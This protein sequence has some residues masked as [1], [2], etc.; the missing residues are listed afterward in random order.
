MS[1]T[2]DELKQ[3]AQASIEQRGHQLG[4]WRD[5][6][7]HSSAD[8]KACSMGVTVTPRTAPNEIDIGGPACGMHC[9]GVTACPGCGGELYLLTALLKPTTSATSTPWQSRD[10]SFYI[11]GTCKHCRETI[12]VGVNVAD[13]PIV[14]PF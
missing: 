4:E 10:A 3:E 1:K 6:P 14:V 12:E 2:L 7:L 5:G 9:P 8:C 11:I 13:Q